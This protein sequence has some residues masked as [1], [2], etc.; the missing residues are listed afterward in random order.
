MI[1][2]NSP[3]SGDTPTIKEILLELSI[4]PSIA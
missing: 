4:V 1:L 2:S 3:V